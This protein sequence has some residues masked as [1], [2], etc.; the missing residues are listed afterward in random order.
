MNQLCIDSKHL[1]K[2]II[3]MF[4]FYFIKF[5]IFSHSKPQYII[6]RHYNLLKI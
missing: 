4:R 1:L 5:S 6:T 3:F 2:N